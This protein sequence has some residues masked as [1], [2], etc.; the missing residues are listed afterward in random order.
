MPS[1][2]PPLLMGAAVLFWGAQTGLLPFALVL[3]PLFEAAHLCRWRWDLSRRDVHHI[4]DLCTVVFAGMALY[5]FATAGGARAAGGRHALTLLFQWAPLALAPIVAGQ[6]YSV[7]EIA[8]LSDPGV[9]HYHEKR[10]VGICT[11]L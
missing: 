10:G 9:F 7:R 8:I 6:L 2:P 3:A 11:E 4:S 5:L 1:A